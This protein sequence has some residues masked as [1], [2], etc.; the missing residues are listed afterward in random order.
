[1]TNSRRHPDPGPEIRAKRG[2][3]LAHKRS[4]GVPEYWS[5]GEDPIGLSL[6]CPSVISPCSTISPAL[7]HSNTP[8]LHPSITPLICFP[9]P[10]HEIENAPDLV[11]LRG[12]FGRT[13]R[14]A[15]AG[16]GARPGLDCRLVRPLAASPLGAGRRQALA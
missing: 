4:D 9:L 6:R 15:P 2:I 11:S 14:V 12:D 10:I 3:R 13:G 7:Q 5:V 8:F 16:A 1:M